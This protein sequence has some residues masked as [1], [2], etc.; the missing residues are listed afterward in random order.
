MI[1]YSIIIA[2]YNRPAEIKELLQ[3]LSEQ[4][5]EHSFEVV[6][7]EDGSS[8]SS[9][10]IVASFED[11]LTVSYY[12][13]VNGG[14]GDT[15]NFGMQ[16]AKGNYFIILD[17]DCVL[18]AGY[19]DRVDQ[20][21]EESYVDYF[22]GPDAALHSFSAIQK[23]INYTMTSLLTTGGIRGT[24]QRIEK[25]QPRGF[26]M[27]I[28]KEA[29]EASK[30][31]RK[32]YIGEDVDL[33]IRLWELG[34]KSELFPEAFVYHKR[35][36]NWVKFYK[37]VNNFGKARP[38]LNKNY[39]KY[40]KITYWFPSLFIFGGFL[41]FIGALFK[42]YILLYVFIFYFFLIF[43]GASVSNKSIKVGLFA[44]V[45]TLVQFFGYGL[46]FI[47]SFVKLNINNQNEQKVM[48]KMFHR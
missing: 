23:A 39:P 9:K 7:V 44:I 4:T 17:S 45:S 12:N 28:S 36:I 27:G 33:S 32:I 2:V 15:R 21:L 19:L 26:N 34:F 29:F 43:I 48:P 42:I 18:P 24:S 3:S 47:Q 30:G 6:V 1:H 13:K 11:K 38:I 22:G 37:Q 14:P 40:N 35:R 10:D 20:Y 5:Y 46:G 25:F 41:S 8:I 16:R 31:Y